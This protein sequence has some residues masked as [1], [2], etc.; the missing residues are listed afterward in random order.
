MLK[1]HGTPKAMLSEHLQAMAHH[2]RRVR[3][4]LDAVH[5]G[6]IEDPCGCAADREHDGTHMDGCPWQ[7]AMDAAEALLG[8]FEA[9]PGAR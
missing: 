2:A 1:W 5:A 6:E 9:A 7:Q 4:V 3:E 8:L